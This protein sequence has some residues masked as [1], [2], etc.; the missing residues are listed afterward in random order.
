MMRCLILGELNFFERLDLRVFMG[1][2]G[3][4]IVI[5]LAFRFT[6]SSLLVTE[7]S[8][9]LSEVSWDINS[10]SGISAIEEPFNAPMLGTSSASR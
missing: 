4:L 7:L 9:D 3:F 10:G 5:T 8:W 1:V 2:S 6:K